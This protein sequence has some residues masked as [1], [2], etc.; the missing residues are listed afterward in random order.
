VTPLEPSRFRSPLLEPLPPE[1]A[2]HGRRTL[3]RRRLI[4]ALALAVAALCA[5]AVELRWLPAEGP[6]RALYRL[7]DEVYLPL[8]GY[9]FT[10]L[11]PGSW[12]YLLAG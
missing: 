6:A 11:Y 12:I 10:W 9:A 2:G 5:V 8:K 4:V 3:V 7:H 1:P